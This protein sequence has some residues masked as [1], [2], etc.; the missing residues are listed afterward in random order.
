MRMPPRASHGVPQ[1]LH[2]RPRLDR[3]LL[4]TVVATAVMAIAI[5]TVVAMETAVVVITM[6]VAAIKVVTAETTVETDVFINAEK[7]P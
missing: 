2:H 3:H 1:R 7:H 5:T 4:V 6:V